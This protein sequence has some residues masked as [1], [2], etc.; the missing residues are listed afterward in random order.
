MPRQ[1]GVSKGA[2][3]RNRGAQQWTWAL[4]SA[5]PSALCRYRLPSARRAA[6]QVQ[7]SAHRPHSRRE[8][9]PGP[10]SRPQ[11]LEPL[12]GQ[13]AC[14]VSPD[15]R[16]WLL[17]LAMEVRRKVL[18]LHGTS[19]VDVNTFLTYLSGVFLTTGC[20]TC[21]LCHRDGFFP[22][23]APAPASSGPL[24]GSSPLPS[25]TSGEGQ[26]LALH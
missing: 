25:Q 15:A 3:P 9:S 5:A 20:L 8:P 2:F 23:R 1:C 11:A 26:G 12:P 22:Y 21:T 6:E 18:H 14:P 7:P 17:R 10:A 16:R 13:S 24:C 4:P 19:V